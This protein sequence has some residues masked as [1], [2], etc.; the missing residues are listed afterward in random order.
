AVA[1]GGEPLL[2]GIARG[3]GGALLGFAIGVD[4]RA[5]LRADIVALAHALGRVVTLPEELEQAGVADQL[6]V[7]DDEHRLGMA[8]AAAAHLLVARVRRRPAGIADGG[9]IDAFLLPEAALGPPKAA[10]AED[11]LLEPGRERRGERACAYEVRLVKRHRRGATRQ[12]LARAR[13]FQLLPREGP[14]DRLPRW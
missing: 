2:I 14:H 6:G 10:E 8:R 1:G 3:L 13:Q 5:V 9:H 4:R 11:R 7:V 12:R